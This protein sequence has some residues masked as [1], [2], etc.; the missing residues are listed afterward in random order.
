MNRFYYSHNLE[1]IHIS[2]IEK[3]ISPR[4]QSNSY[5]HNEIFTL[6][7]NPLG[8]EWFKKHLIDRFQALSPGFIMTF[9]QFVNELYSKIQWVYSEHKKTAKDNPILMTPSAKILLIK[10]TLDSLKEDQRLTGYYKPLW[11]YWGFK[12][13][14]ISFLTSIK[15]ELLPQTGIGDSDPDI[16]VTRS[17]EE[18]LQS[19]SKTHKGL[20]DKYKD[21]TI[22]LSE[23]ENMRV[24][25]SLID[26]EDMIEQVISYLLEEQLGFLNQTRRI[27]L[28]NVDSLSYNDLNLIKTLS[29]KGIEWVVTFYYD[30]ERPKLFSAGQKIKDYLLDLG[31]KGETKKSKLKDFSKRDFSINEL[32][33]NIFNDLKN[34]SERLPFD[35]SSI[36]LIRGNS[37]TD[38]VVKVGKQ[39]KQLLFNDPALNP[40]DI[41]L[42]VRNH[43]S[44]KD[45]I[46]DAFKKLKVPIYHNFKENISHQKLVPVLLQILELK[47]HNYPSETLMSFIKSNYV[48]LRGDSIDKPHY[49]TRT[50]VRN[51]DRYYQNIKSSDRDV[52]WYLKSLKAKAHS[53]SNVDHLT[54]CILYLER[55]KDEIDRFPAPQEKA[56]IHEMIKIWREHIID[57]FSILYN[58]YNSTDLEIVQ[59]DS[60]VLKSFLDLLGEYGY[61]Q[62]HVQ[63]E[64]MT[65]YSFYSTVKELLSAATVSFKNTRSGHVHCMNPYDIQ[66]IPYKKV[67]AIGL[68]EGEFPKKEALNCIIRDTEKKSL[69]QSYE[70]FK[71]S[72]QQITQE[73]F[74]FFNCLNSAIEEL[75]VSYPLLDN[76]VR[77]TLPSFFLDELAYHLSKPLDDLNLDIENDE[78]YY[79]DEVYNYYGQIKGQEVSSDQG[80]LD[81]LILMSNLDQSHI[82]LI[83]DKVTVEKLRSS[84]NFSEYEGVLDGDGHKGQLINY[85]NDAFT[86]ISSSHLE[87]YGQCPHRFFFYDILRLRKRKE[88]EDTLS[89][90]DKG[91]AVHSILYR[92]YQKRL[93]TPELFDINNMDWVKKEIR[94]I[95]H[96]FFEDEIQETRQNPLIWGREFNTIVHE[97]C[98]FVEKDL[99][100][101]K[102][103]KPVGLE[104]KFNDDQ[105]L[106]SVDLLDENGERLV[107]V[108]GA[109]DRI[110]LLM[111]ESEIRVI[112]Y[113]SGGEISNPR[114]KEDLKKGMRFQP[115]LYSLKAKDIYKLPIN[116]WN[117]YFVLNNKHKPIKRA[118]IDLNE[119]VD[120]SMTATYNELSKYYIKSYLHLIRQGNYHGVPKDCKDYCEF[121]NICRVDLKLAKDKETHQPFWESLE[122][123]LENLEKNH[124]L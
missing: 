70:V 38:E 85:L 94:A 105:D 57:T 106:N 47:V 109:I 60:V 124:S 32:T 84:L 88:R 40:H 3:E 120:K 108:K 63:Q 35:S 62:S 25:N 29:G 122:D 118:F 36:H 113:K 117:Y 119:Q 111:D 34:P 55:L 93:E 33:K 112:D 101:N 39:I 69:N 56:S 116:T 115:Y 16:K 12:R 92:L 10:K 7:V 6:F 4:I 1:A 67:F 49:N 15:K 2:L 9:S 86:D 103:F 13:D 24:S 44:Y 121:K 28:F 21:L 42:I 97:L 78:F 102:D 11:E 74:Y 59:R 14:L 73:Q 72:D 19:N 110:D 45:L 8:Q 18:W 54:N 61:Y 26:H 48:Y 37:L 77:D 83:N 123:V 89:S 27:Y 98:L 51:I 64:E 82:Q 95:S 50:I 87:R 20:K 114:L 80:K 107:R 41:A 65:F 79:D 91:N 53:D 96:A 71:D 31:F 5:L 104:I 90:S 17:I 68:F 46:I 66:G 76:S 43:S 75:Y 22:I 100:E 30:P 52:L 81:Q 23:Y 99:T 58:V